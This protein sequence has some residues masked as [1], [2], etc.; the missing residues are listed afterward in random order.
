MNTIA[1]IFLLMYAPSM[2]DY[3]IEVN[4]RQVATFT[5]EAICEDAAS[6]ANSQTEAHY[7]CEAK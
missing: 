3:D 4:A 7:W 2:T 6:I 5:T 1:A